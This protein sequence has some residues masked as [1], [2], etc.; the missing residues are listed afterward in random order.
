MKSLMMSIALM[1]S[2]NS[3]A[4]DYQSPVKE[5]KVTVIN[6]TKGQPI[7]PPVLT[8]HSPKFK[9]FEL[10]M[11]ATK[12][13]AVLAQDGV[14]SELVSELEASKKVVRSTTAEGVIMPGQKAELM[15]QAN[16]TRFKLSIVGMLA[17]TNDAI[18]SA[19]SLP[20]GLKKGQ[21]Y[22]TLA[23]V[24]DAGAET[25]T[26]SCSQIPAPPCGNPM[27]GTNGGEGFV[28]PHEGLT[29]VGD[30]DPAR[31]AFSSV[32]AKIIVERVQ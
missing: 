19:T 12:G 25:N 16:D 28:R 15:I 27:V 26:E 6:L 9:L 21:K 2:M 4:K 10:G 31:D 20:T 24:Y 29:G 5:F 30:L 18:V 1:A 17:R 7:T 14:T 8:V 23:K 13:L 22:S 32:A 3:Y 11:P